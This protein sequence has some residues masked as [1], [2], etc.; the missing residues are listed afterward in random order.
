[1]PKILQTLQKL[2][3]AIYARVS[4]DQQAEKGYSIET[5]L[6]ACRKMAAALGATTVLEFID[7]GYSGEF[8][9]RPAMERLRTAISKKS[10]H[11]V[12]VY[13][14]D[15]LARKL[16]HQLI[17]TDEIEKS[18]AE[19][20]FVSVNF[21]STPEGRLFYSMRG[22]VAEFEKEKIKERTNRG[23]RGKLRRG[24]LVSAHRPF[25]YNLIDDMYVINE[26]EAKIVRLMYDMLVNQK[27]GTPTIARILNKMGVLTTQ[28]ALWSSSTVYKLLSSERNCGVHNALQWYNQKIS[29]DKSI[30]IRRD[31]S[32][33]IPVAIPAIISR[34]LWEAAQKQLAE[35]KVVSK[36]NTKTI[37]PL[38]GIAYCGICGKRLGV[39]YGRL[40]TYYWCLSQYGLNKRP[41]GARTV[42]T[43]ILENSVWDIVADVCKSQKSINS[44]LRDYATKVPDNSGKL[45]ELKKLEQN[46]QKLLKKRETAMR[47]FS[48]GIIDDNEIE[49]QLTELKNKLQQTASDKAQL[50]AL[51]T[52]DIQPHRSGA[53]ISEYFRA[54]TY[55]GMDLQEKKDVLD[56]LLSRVEV[57]RTDTNQR[58]DCELD[59]RLHF[60]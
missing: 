58:G 11:T 48:Q 60:H 5:Q 33:W 54:N 26:K 3:F 59:I 37:H 10:I 41:C 32:E 29:L 31:K 17:I 34:E 38:Q 19:L 22:A 16:A 7:D 9:D 21:E 13:D 36:R 56:Y 45:A 42:L 4:T 40:S 51:L 8:I 15:R 18:G 1:M 55:A 20:K 39:K 14:P 50:Q 46:E 12:I 52:T 6:E 43:D 28:N 57:I 23:K 2:I 49:Q 24:K 53:E 44:Y 25:G 27:L 30:K 35:N 47:W